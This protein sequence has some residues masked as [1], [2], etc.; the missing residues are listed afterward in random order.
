MTR[1]TWRPGDVLLIIDM[2]NTFAFDHGDALSQQADAIVGT[3]R[4]LRAACHRE[5]RPV[6]YVNDNFGQWRQ[7]FDDLLRRAGRPGSRGRHIAEAL[8]PTRQDLFVLKPRHSVFYQT[9]LPSL[10]EALEARR[11]ILTGIA[12]DSCV[13]CSATEAHV[14][15]FDLWVPAGAVASLT[16]DRTER[17]LAY[18]KESLGGDIAPAGA[19]KGRGGDTRAKR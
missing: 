7:G 6:V 5:K 9:P 3:V 16:A 19:A 4:G 8:R 13:L 14:R 15:G 12:A 18:V 1:Q 11:L 2:I 10:L 17:A